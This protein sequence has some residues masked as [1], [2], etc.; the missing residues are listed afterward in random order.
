MNQSLCRIVIIALLMLRLLHLA[1]LLQLFLWENS[2]HCFLK[3]LYRVRDARILFLDD[4][5]VRGTQLKDNVVK[6]KEC[7]V[8]EVHMRISSPPFRYPCYFGT[9]IDSPERLIANNM[10][11]PEIGKKIG[12]DSLGFLSLENIV[13]V[14]E[15]SDCQFCTGCFSGEYP[16]NV[17]N[18]GK[19]SKF[20]RKISENND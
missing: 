18:A 6:L 12:V 17:E 2:N 7:G 16:L 3:S 14:A 11:I 8:K 19:V 13:K 9:D 5:I 15:N 1:I 4:S 10:T 20:D